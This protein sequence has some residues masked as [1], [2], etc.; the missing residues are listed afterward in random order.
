MCRVRT[1]SQNVRRNAGSFY[2]RIESCT[3]HQVGC[4]R[5]AHA[6]AILIIIMT[7]FSSLLFPLLLGIH[8]FVHR[9]FLALVC[10][11]GFACA[12]GK[13]GSLWSLSRVFFCAVMAV[14]W[15]L[16]ALSIVMGFVR[17]HGMGSFARGCSTFA[18][19]FCFVI[20]FLDFPSTRF[21]RTAPRFRQLRSCVC[22]LF[23]FCFVNGFV[24][25]LRQ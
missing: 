16:R 7:T 18:A 21:I 20:P 1:R 8:W 2:K 11:F 25:T 22:F 12:R 23:S 6:Y 5:F 10:S 24:R 15:F 3:T 9:A 19:C 13:T 14:F 17:C 4:S